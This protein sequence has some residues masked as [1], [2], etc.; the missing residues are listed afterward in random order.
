MTKRKMNTEDFETKLFKVDTLYSEREHWVHLWGRTS[1][2][3]AE[4][5]EKYVSQ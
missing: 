5:T 2:W 4:D 1:E 3:I